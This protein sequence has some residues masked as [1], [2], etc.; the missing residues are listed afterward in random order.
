MNISWM[1][2]QKKT[3]KKKNEILE[4]SGFIVFEHLLKVNS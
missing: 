1:R 2:K 3:K 4:L